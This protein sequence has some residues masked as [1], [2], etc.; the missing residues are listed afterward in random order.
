MFPWQLNIRS[1][2]GPNIE[3][4]LASMAYPWHAHATFITDC[5]EN[6]KEGDRDSLCPT[7][8]VSGSLYEEWVVQG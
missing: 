7:G 6:P 4:A 8:T 1:A 3:A 5:C 2:Q